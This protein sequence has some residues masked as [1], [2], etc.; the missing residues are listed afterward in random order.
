MIHLLRW[1]GLA[2]GAW[3]LLFLAGPDPH[4]FHRNTKT[5]RT[6]AW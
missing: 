2:L 6:N 3:L 4:P 1:I 5:K